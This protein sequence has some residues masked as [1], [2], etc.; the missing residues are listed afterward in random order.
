MIET[1][2]NSTLL[3]LL[4][5]LLIIISIILVIVFS[6]QIIKNESIFSKALGYSTLII[7][8]TYNIYN[9]SPAN[10]IVSESLPFHLCDVLA[11]TAVITLLTKNKKASTFLY[12]CAIPLASQAI[13][14]PTGEQNPLLFRF[15][16]FWTLH[17]SII[18]CSVYDI[19]IRKYRPT[20]KSYF[21]TLVCDIIYVII[22]LPINIIF[23][24]NYGFIGNTSPDIPTLI[25]ILGPWPLRV[26]W[27]FLA[28][29]FI[30]FL[31]Y[32]PWRIK[33]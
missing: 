20:I 21:F 26:L 25:D 10:F 4:M 6:N 31:M 15:W 16:L 33:S 19:I 3:H 8:I 24:F 7:W 9:F 27:I 32:L 12:F 29:A 22:I 23:N 28:V 17:A 13:I 5:I 11:I 1:L 14:T 2:I 30:Q 18:I